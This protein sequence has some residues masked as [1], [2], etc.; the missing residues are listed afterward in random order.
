VCDHQMGI[1]LVEA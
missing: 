1:W